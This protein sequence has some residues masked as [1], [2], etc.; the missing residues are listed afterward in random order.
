MCML[1]LM[2]LTQEYR[3][4]KEATTKSPPIKIVENT[5]DISSKIH[6]EVNYCEGKSTSL[7]DRSNIPRERRH[8]NYYPESFILDKHEGEIKSDLI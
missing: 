2:R 5:A 4:L 6:I 3:K 7:A 8:N 1:Y